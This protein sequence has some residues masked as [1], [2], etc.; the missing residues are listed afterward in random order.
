M[1][2]SRGKDIDRKNTYPEVRYVKDTEKDQGGEPTT[3]QRS[4][5]YQ[6]TNDTR[7]LLET[8]TDLRR[9]VLLFWISLPIR[10]IVVT[11]E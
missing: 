1:V 3:V 9:L 7:G 8:L 10:W 4:C 11:F 5:V 2:H 6:R